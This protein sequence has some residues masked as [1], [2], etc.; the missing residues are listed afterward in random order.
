MTA[1]IIPF[2]KRK[3]VL[4]DPAK[5]KEEQYELADV[6]LGLA[7]DAENGDITEICIALVETDGDVDRTYLTPRQSTR[8]LKAIDLLKKRVLEVLAEQGAR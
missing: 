6:L 8:M 1:K 7:A 2:G 3:K 5:T 4:Y